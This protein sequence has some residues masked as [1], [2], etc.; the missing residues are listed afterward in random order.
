MEHCEW[1]VA[2]KTLRNS[3]ISHMKSE[4]RLHRF[5]SRASTDL[6]T[7]KDEGAESVPDKIYDLDEHMQEKWRVMK[8]WDA[9]V[10]TGYDYAVEGIS[11][12]EASER[13]RGIR[14]KRE[15]ELGIQVR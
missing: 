8:A 10:R 2:G 4:W 12:K 11:Q 14:L 5:E 13:Y 9:F 15:R 3:F 6:I 7:H 1:N